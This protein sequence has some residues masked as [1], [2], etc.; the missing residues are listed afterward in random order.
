M[1]AGDEAGLTSL[2]LMQSLRDVGT[3][4]PRLV[5]LLMQGGTG[6]A[7]C[8]AAGSECIGSNAAHIVSQDILD[9]FA[10]LGV[11]TRVMEPLPTTEFT[12]QV[13]G[14]S[15][16][17]WGM[18]FNKLRVFGMTE[19]RKLLWFDSDTI[20]LRNVDHLL[21]QPEFT[22]AFTNDCNNRNAAYKISGGFWVVEPSDARMNEILELTRTGKLAPEQEW[23]LGDM[24]IALFL[25]A[26]FSRASRQDG[27]WP[28]SYDLRQGRVPGVEL[29]DPATRRGA[30]GRRSMRSLP[31]QVAARAREGKSPWFPLDVRYDYL[32]Q[33]RHGWGSEEGF[34]NGLKQVPPCV[35][36]SMMLWYSKL[37]RAMNGSRRFSGGVGPAATSVVDLTKPADIL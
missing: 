16:S 9:A 13:A 23:R 35:R 15:R 3:R 26:K 36:Q 37:L 24:E 28:A 30:S 2:A 8:H 14:G 17:F 31:E 5:V 21:V 22:A 12:K 6:S 10:R 34:V 25:F 19:F 29:Y 27:F 18:A 33:D 32:V 7:D 1:A 20:M 4:V 11:E